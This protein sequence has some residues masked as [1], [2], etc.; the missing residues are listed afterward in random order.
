[1]FGG[2]PPPMGGMMPGPPGPPF[3]MGYQ[4]QNMRPPF[5]PY[6]VRIVMNRMTKNASIYLI[7]LKMLIL[8]P[9]P[10]PRGRAFTQ[11]LGGLG[12]DSW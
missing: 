5:P 8:L 10:E 7:P 9:S 1:M 4:Q 2:G 3:G 12:L 6:M 11:C